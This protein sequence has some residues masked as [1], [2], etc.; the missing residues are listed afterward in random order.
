M[1]CYG[2]AMRK[3]ILVLIA[4]IALVQPIPANA[5]TTIKYTGQKEGKAC[6]V[7][8]V[9]KVVKLPNGTQLACISSNKVQK[10]QQFGKKAA[11]TKK[12]EV[13]FSQVCAKIKLAAYAHNEFRNDD[14]ADDF[15]DR[16]YGKIRS[17]FKEAATLMRSM[18]GNYTD[19]IADAKSAGVNAR[20]VN[21]GLTYA[22]ENLYSACD[23]SED[24]VWKNF[25]KWMG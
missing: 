14:E 10:W 1:L 11:T 13:T 21:A 15:Y 18:S 5:S 9:N 8:E 22:E 20:G 3:K 17:Y 24:A 25:E 16:W 7:A 4:T 19:L 6:A 2:S 12:S 23:I